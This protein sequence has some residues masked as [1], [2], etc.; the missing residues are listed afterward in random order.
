MIRLL[1]ALLLCAA[2]TPTI[3]SRYVDLAKL[4]VPPRERFPDAS[5]VVLLREDIILNGVGPKA[6]SHQWMRHDVVAFLD[7][8][9]LDR[10]NLRCV[11]SG[12]QDVV[13]FRARVRRPDGR[14]H[15]IDARDT[16]TEPYRIGEKAVKGK[17]RRVAVPGV[18]V[19]SVLETVCVL[20]ADYLL[21]WSRE[22][23]IDTAPI[24]EY[25][26]DLTVGDRTHYALKTY[27]SKETIQKIPGSSGDRLVWVMRD[28]PAWKDLAWADHWTRTEPWWRFQ[29]LRHRFGRSWADFNRTWAGVADKVAARLDVE[30]ETLDASAPPPPDA[31]ACAGQAKCV[32]ESYWRAVLALARLRSGD[33]AY[34]HTPLGEVFAQGASA[35]VSGAER[36]RLL[37]RWLRAAGIRA[38]HALAGRR[39]DEAPDHAAPS[40]EAFDSLMVLVPQQAGIA[41]DLWLDPHC[42][43]CTPGQLS[44]ERTAVEALVFQARPKF[45]TDPE[46]T[47]TLRLVH[48][49]AVEQGERRTHHRLELR[50]DGDGQLSTTTDFTHHR[51]WD[52]WN[53]RDQWT[54]SKWRDDEVETLDRLDL[55]AS[56]V[57]L[58]P[59]PF[60]RE[61]ARLSAS[62]TADLRRYAALDGPDLAVPLTLLGRV[63]VFDAEK[64]ETDLVRVRGS[65]DVDELV[66][67][68]PPGFRVVY[69]PPSAAGESQG[70]SYALTAEVRPDGAAVVRRV[71]ETR[72]GRFPASGYTALRRLQLEAAELSRQ[73]VIMRPIS[74][75]PVT[76]PGP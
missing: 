20:K 59:K 49:Q 52:A 27:N 6:W 38:D 56:N 72:P 43:L 12:K 71:F 42:D 11:E 2:C 32:V 60:D 51:A 76:P 8:R 23:I 70:I 3:P 75:A 40:W 73:L 17:V 4:E 63:F 67:V 15:E 45:G 44:P 18:T 41:A 64:Q 55:T 10:A 58:V 50:T 69:A 7:E 62:G 14:V 48:G 35:G 13:E 39:F 34:E 57:T 28:L 66:F 29:A 65:R 24:V 25:R 9:G 54:A 47:G 31:S 46:V 33:G 21:T 16:F 53:A 30:A 1:W 61:G 19:G 37:V 74:D 22:R 5:A 36:A 26:L 68:P